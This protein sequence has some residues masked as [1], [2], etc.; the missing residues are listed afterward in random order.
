MNKLQ[1]SFLLFPVQFSPK[2]CDVVALNVPVRDADSG[3]LEQLLL[4]LVHLVGGR[5]NVEQDDLGVAVHEPAAA[6][7]AVSVR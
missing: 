7:D 2:K 4:E 1:K 6:V 3:L 5:T